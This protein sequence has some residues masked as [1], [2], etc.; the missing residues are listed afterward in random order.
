MGIFEK[1]SNNANCA[2]IFYLFSLRA[3]AA[4][5]NADKKITLKLCDSIQKNA[6]LMLKTKQRL[7]KERN[8]LFEAATFLLLSGVKT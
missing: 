1:E 6:G 5:A 8:I 7:K 3:K 2:S 4:C